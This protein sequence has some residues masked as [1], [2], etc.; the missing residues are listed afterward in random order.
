M[1]WSLFILGMMHILFMVFL[2]VAIGII[3][4]LGYD[5]IRWTIKRLRDDF[6][7]Q[8]RRETRRKTTY[9]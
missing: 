2:F 7:S 1:V 4:I 9:K 3:L 8:K 6:R 5:D